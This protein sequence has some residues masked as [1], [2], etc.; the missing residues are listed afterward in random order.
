MIDRVSG[1]KEVGGGK[2]DH[3]KRK[4]KEIMLDL[5]IT[6]C[7]NQGLLLVLLFVVV[8][9]VMTQTKAT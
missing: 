5:I 6:T 1:K 4:G 3:V 2:G 9:V 8:V 7:K